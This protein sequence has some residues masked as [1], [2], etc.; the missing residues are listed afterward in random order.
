V[1]KKQ[2][3]SKEYELVGKVILLPNAEFQYLAGRENKGDF[4]EGLDFCTV[5]I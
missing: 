1:I 3:R 5:V 4:L 2:R